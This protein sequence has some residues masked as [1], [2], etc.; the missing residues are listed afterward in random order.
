MDVLEF[1]GRLFQ[2]PAAD[3]SGHE[4]SIEFRA[5][6]ETDDSSRLLVSLW[7]HAAEEKVAGRVLAAG[8]FRDV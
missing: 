4:L 2:N 8:G 3:G 1:C 7:H 5:S 6:S